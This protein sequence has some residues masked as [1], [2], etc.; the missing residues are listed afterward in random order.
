[1]KFC[2]KCGAELCDEAI[3]CVKCGCMVGNTPLP[4]SKPIKVKPPRPPR[5]NG[6]PS[7]L[8]VVS[9]FVHSLALA[10]SL[11]FLFLGFGDPYVRS[12]LETEKVL[13]EEYITGV[14]TYFNLDS[15]IIIIALIFSGVALAFGIISFVMTLFEKHKFERLFTSIS[16]LT[17]SIISFTLTFILLCL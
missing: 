4:Q 3:I 8:L 10:I 11:F 1:M 6:E 15:D 9:N 7:I 13:K 14:S 5:A 2:T 16:R 17:V 12:R